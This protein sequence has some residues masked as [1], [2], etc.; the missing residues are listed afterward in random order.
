[1][2]R[3]ILNILW[4]LLAGW[5]LA[6]AY[7]LAGTVLMVTVIGFP[8]GVQAWKLAG[9]VLWPFG[10]VAIPAQDSSE[11]WST[12]GNVFWLVLAGWWIALLHVLGGIL[13]CISIIGIPFGLQSFKMAGMALWPFGRTI[14][15]AST[16]DQGSNSVFYVD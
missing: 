1:M 2:L 3:I 15:D 8:F 10:R 11:G 16:V 12:V 6:I 14:V 4:L 9:F 13:L 7:A 5:E